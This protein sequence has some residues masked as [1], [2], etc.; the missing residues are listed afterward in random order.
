[1]GAPLR[2]HEEFIT[3][4][5]PEVSPTMISQYDLCAS[6]NCHTADCSETDRLNVSSGDVVERSRQARRPTPPGPATTNTSRQ[7]L[8]RRL[9]RKHASVFDLRVLACQCALRERALSASHSGPTPGGPRVIFHLSKA[10]SY[11]PVINSLREQF[12]AH[13]RSRACSSCA[14]SPAPR[15]RCDA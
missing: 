15:R 6:F 12:G 11:Q 4:P 7:L 3:R 5:N 10:I 1:M 9:P 8:G 2:A 14:K 13:N